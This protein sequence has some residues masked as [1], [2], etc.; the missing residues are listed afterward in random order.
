M[1][2]QVLKLKL[3]EVNEGASTGFDRPPFL[4][5]LS[6][7]I[8]Q[9]MLFEGQKR[10][11]EWPDLELLWYGKIF[12]WARE[13][14]PSPCTVF[15]FGMREVLVWGA[16]TLSVLCWCSPCGHSRT[17][18]WLH[19]QRLCAQQQP[20]LHHTPCNGQPV[21]RPA[22]PLLL[23]FVSRSAQTLFRRSA[24]FVWQS[25]RVNIKLFKSS[26]VFH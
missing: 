24:S 6:R 16:V 26:L 19:W 1:D 10:P 8:L 18:E 13:Y 14:K 25:F 4:A 5:K 7:L 21:F 9:F 17:W 20:G 12:I 11:R 22:N 3:E 15:H 23:S 2:T